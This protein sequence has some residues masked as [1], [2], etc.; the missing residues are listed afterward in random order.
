MSERVEETL[1]Q[2]KAERD[3]Y[4]RELLKLLPMDPSELTEEQAREM[5]ENGLTV[6]HLI[7]QVKTAAARR[8]QSPER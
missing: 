4:R 2:V 8:R 6:E 1:E 7:V 5:R 3:L